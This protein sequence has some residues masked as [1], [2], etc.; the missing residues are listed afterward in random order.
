MQTSGQNNLQRIME[1]AQGLR[2]QLATA[3]TELTEAEV[4]G[5]AGNGL[6][7]VTLRGSGE[8]TRITIDPTV[9]DP[10]DVHTLE[11]LVVAAFRSATDAIA[12]L[13]DNMTGSLTAGLGG[14]P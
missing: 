3:F 14:L 9:V 13:K 12:L 7:T 4:T 2:A 5:T 1:Q 11:E 6:V 10:H 8:L